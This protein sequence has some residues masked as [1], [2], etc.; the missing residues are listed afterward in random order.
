MLNKI[1]INQKENSELLKKYFKNYYKLNKEKILEKS[2]EN[3]HNMEIKP[4]K[5]SEKR[6]E[7]NKR[8]YEK[9]KLKLINEN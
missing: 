3:Y 9:R 8:A 5:S 6:I 2:K 1:K 7:Y 4:T